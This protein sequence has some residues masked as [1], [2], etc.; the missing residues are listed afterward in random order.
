MYFQSHLGLIS[1]LFLYELKKWEI[2]LFQSHLGLIST[3]LEID[4]NEELKAHFQSHLGLISTVE[5][6]IERARKAAFNP[7]LVWFQLF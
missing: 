6:C 5:E 1:T 2:R 7:I 3:N 4:I